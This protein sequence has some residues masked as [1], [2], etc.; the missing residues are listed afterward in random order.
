[1]SVFKSCRRLYKTQSAVVTIII[2]PGEIQ[3]VSLFHKYLFL[4]LSQPPTKKNPIILKFNCYDYWYQ[5][6]FFLFFSL[7]H[8]R[9]QSCLN[10]RLVELN[11]WGSCA[12]RK[13]L[14]S[15]YYGQHIFLYSCRCVFLT[16]SFIIKKGWLQFFPKI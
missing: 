14:S 9:E 10:N 8:L 15:Y 11:H 16:R 2:I 12:Q 13:Q 3:F 5:L 1:M 7:C 6:N 4:S